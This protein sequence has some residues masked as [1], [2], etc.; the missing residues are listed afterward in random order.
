MKLLGMARMGVQ[1]QRELFAKA[2]FS[3]VKT[4]EERDK[5][6]LCVTGS[7]PE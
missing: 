4:F 1:Q 6:W 7:K 2:G 5:G 3:G